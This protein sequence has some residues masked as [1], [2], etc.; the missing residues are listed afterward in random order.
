MN[1]TIQLYTFQSLGNKV[2]MSKENEKQAG[3]N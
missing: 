2:T 1:I 3:N